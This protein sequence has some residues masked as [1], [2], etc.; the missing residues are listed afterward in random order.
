M[1]VID[2][3]ACAIMEWHNPVLRFNSNHVCP[4]RVKAETQNDSLGLTQAMYRH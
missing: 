3:S 2:L 1:I 4:Y